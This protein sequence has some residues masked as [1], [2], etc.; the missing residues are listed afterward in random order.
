MDH[1][2]NLS[3]LSFVVSSGPRVDLW[4]EFRT[5]GSYADDNAVGRERAEEVVAYMRDNG[6]PMVVGHIVQAIVARGIYGGLEVGFFGHFGVVICTA[7]A[8]A[9]NEP[10]IGAK[11]ASAPAP[12]DTNVVEVDFRRP[13]DRTASA[14]A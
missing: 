4:P 3:M 8:E 7:P 14:S 13:M 5:T 10:M 6:A 11:P 1:Q 2:P 9:A 12:A